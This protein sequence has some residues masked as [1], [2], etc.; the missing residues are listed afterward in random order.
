M[1]DGIQKISDLLLT[2]DFDRSNPP[3]QL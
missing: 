2:S 3:T 1:R